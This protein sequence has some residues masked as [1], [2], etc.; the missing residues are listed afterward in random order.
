LLAGEAQA[1]SALAPKALRE[2]LGYDDYD[3]RA[4]PYILGA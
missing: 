4:K 3:R 1:T 2:V